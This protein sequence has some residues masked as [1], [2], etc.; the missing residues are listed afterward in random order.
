MYTLG[1]LIERT[2][3]GTKLLQRSQSELSRLQTDHYAQDATIDAITRDQ[4]IPADQYSSQCLSNIRTAF[5]DFSSDNPVSYISINPTSSASTE[6]FGFLSDRQGY[7]LSLGNSKRLIA[8][9]FKPSENAVSFV[10]DMWFQLDNP[11]NGQSNVIIKQGN[12]P[13]V[14]ISKSGSGLRFSL[15]NGSSNT[16]TLASESEEREWHYIKLDKSLSIGSDGIPIK[17]YQLTVNNESPINVQSG[18]GF[19]AS[20]NDDWSFGEGS[21]QLNLATLRA[22]SHLA[23]QPPDISDQT[24]N[25]RSTLLNVTQ[26]KL[27]LRL[28]F[29]GR[30]SLY[31]NSWQRSIGIFSMDGETRVTEFTTPA[32]STKRFPPAPTDLFKLFRCTSSS[33]QPMPLTLQRTRNLVIDEVIWQ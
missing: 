15:L 28:A 3:A 17:T 25:D 32:L 23:L 1:A 18:S 11:E 27:N 22:W 19:A 26:D 6:W 20:S 10:M 29:D 12:Q 24:I 5:S 30:N 7:A 9:S 4:T 16:V 2:P 8:S 31:N 33:Q 14:S 21:M 13:L